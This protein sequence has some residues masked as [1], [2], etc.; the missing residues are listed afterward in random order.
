MSYKQF[1]GEVGGNIA[2]NIP[3]NYFAQILRLKGVWLDL[4]TRTNQIDC[5]CFDF[6]YGT[7]DPDCDNCKGTGSVV[8]F[9]SEPEHSFKAILTIN[10][11]FSQDQHQRLHAK[12]GPV[13]SVDGTVF[14]EGRYWEII[15]L[16]DIIVWRPE[17]DPAGYE[18]KIISKN[19]RLGN[20]NE[21]V[22]IR[23]DFERHPYQVL[24]EAENIKKF[25]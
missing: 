2:P 21:I 8:G 3:R 7:A 17:F 9:T 25:I 19:P 4:Y 11:E 6:D 1:E 13:D 24:P 5:T 12:A 16:E 18:L 23:C 20:Q 14:V 10:P 15:H 22:F